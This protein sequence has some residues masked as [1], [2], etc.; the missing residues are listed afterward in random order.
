MSTF[1][2]KTIQSEDND[3]IASKETIEDIIELDTIALLKKEPFYAYLLVK[4]HKKI[5][6]SVPIAGVAVVNGDIHLFINPE[7]YTAFTKSERIAILKHE[8]LHVILIHYLRRKD[9]DP[10]LF[11][12][13][14]DIAINQLINTEHYKL[15]NICLYPHHYNLPEDKSAE[16]YYKILF[17]RNEEIKIPE[18]LLNTLG[19]LLS[20]C[21][22]CNGTGNEP[23]NGQGQQEDEG[24]GNQGNPCSS[25]GGSGKSQSKGQ[26]QGKGKGEGSGSRAPAF[27]GMHPTWDRSTE[28]SEDVAEAIVRSMVQEAY[29][30]SQGNVPGEISAL[31]SNLLTSKINWRAIFRNF[32]ARQRH[33]NKKHTWKRPNRRLDRQVMGYKKTK[34]LHVYV[35]IDTSGSVGSKELEMFNGELQKMYEAGTEITVIECDAAIQNIYQYTKNIEPTFK[36]RGGTDFRPPFEHVLNNNLRPDAI[37]YLTDG[38]GSAPASCPFPVLW[39]LTP[40]SQ[41]PNSEDGGEVRYGSQIVLQD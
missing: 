33:T 14:A 11:N 24:Q 8:V 20:E 3:L 18:E 10:E 36:G 30:K 22:H 29:D 37:I 25:C 5:E 23:Q 17:Q 15:P 26:G 13:A 4:M 12:I 39:V 16:E 1:P 31:I 27:A 32:V 34:K 21:S 35:F 7:R 19:K 40:D 6:R 38:Y 41:R 28:I 2:E 9:R